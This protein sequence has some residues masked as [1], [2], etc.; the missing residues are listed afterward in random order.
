MRHMDIKALAL[1]DQGLSS[2]RHIDDSALGDLPHCR[3]KRFDM[4]R[5]VKMATYTDSIALG[6]DEYTKDAPN[7][8]A[9]IDG[10]KLMWKMVPLVCTLL[11]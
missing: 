4:V 10:L 8:Q 7:G 5:A 11:G 1:V 6:Q 9:S 2:C 3:V